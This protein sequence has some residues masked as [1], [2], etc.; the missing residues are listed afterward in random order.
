MVCEIEI[1]KFS[2]FETSYHGKKKLHSLQLFDAGGEAVLKIYLKGKDPVKFLKIKSKQ[3]V[4]YNFEV[5]KINVK[6]L[7]QFLRTK[8][9][10]LSQIYMR[11][12]NLLWREV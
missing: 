7:L 8:R 11:L 5:Q 1:V 10:H 3:K 4:D 12:P 6:N 9:V 2:F